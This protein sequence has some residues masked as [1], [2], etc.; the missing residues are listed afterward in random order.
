MRLRSYRI[1]SLLLFCA[2]VFGT[3]EVSFAQG[4][5]ERVNR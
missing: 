3:V 4:A 2:L 5:K 1:F